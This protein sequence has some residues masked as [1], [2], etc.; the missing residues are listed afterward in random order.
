MTLEPPS[1]AWVGTYVRALRAA[2]TALAPGEDYV[3]LSGALDHLAALDPANGGDLLDP[4][5]ISP[6][7]GMPLYAWLER[8]RAEAELAQATTVDPDD[9]EIARVTGLD[10]VLGAR[11]DSRR[12]LYRHLR[13]AELLPATRLGG[14]LRWHGPNE[15]HVVAAFDRLAPDGRW[16]RLRLEL[17]VPTSR[18]G[19]IEV[20]AGRV[21][22]HDNLRHLLTRHASTP[23]TPLRIQIEHATDAQVLRIARSWL[24]PFWFPGVK[25]PRNVPDALGSG[26]LLHASTEVADVNL[27]TS[28]HLDPLEDRPETE[29]PA[30]WREYRERRFAA[31]GAATDAVRSWAEGKGI[32]PLVVPIIR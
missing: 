12:R 22:L 16:M 13:Q 9:E 18:V 11:L 32:R 8:A 30:G 3:P 14:A 20:V 23:L 15:V 26:L 31:A 17:R 10:P 6:T 21:Q 4:P 1:A 5:E 7:S 28:R 19:P 24:G 25:L 2:L 29:P 27:R